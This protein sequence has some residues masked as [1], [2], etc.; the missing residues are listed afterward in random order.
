MKP[1]VWTSW[2]PLAILKRI[3]GKPLPGSAFSPEGYVIKNIG[4]KFAE[5]KGQTEFEE[6]YDHLMTENR[7]GCPFAFGR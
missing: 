1:T 2:E 6:T 3:M 7:G 4:P 5:G